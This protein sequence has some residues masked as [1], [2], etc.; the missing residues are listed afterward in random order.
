[1]KINFA[2]QKV[3]LTGAS[4][5]IGKQISND[6]ENL[7]AK[8]IKL[9]SKQYDLTKKEE[10]SSLVENIASFK[11]IDVCINNAGINIIDNFEDIKVQDY[12][13]IMII[14]AQAPFMIAQ[15]ATKVMKKNNYGRI[16]NISSIFGHCTK[17]KRMCY[18]ASKY[19]LVGM[20]KTMATEMA[21]H[22]ILVNSVAPGFTQTELTTK[23]LGHDG[24]KEMSSM[25][26]MKRLATPKEISKVVLFLASKENSYLTGQNIIVDGGFVNV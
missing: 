16:I 11:K 20:T 7:G 5:G 9:N 18:T 19:A 13:K 1:M 8:V 12:E 23:I 3:L 15:A 2:G 25:I 14:N 22:N 21:P 10:I 26:P 6:L 24:I 4:R 17:E